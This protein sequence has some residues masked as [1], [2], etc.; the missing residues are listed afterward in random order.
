MTVNKRTFVLLALLVVPLFYAIGTGFDFLYTLLYAVLLL[1]AVGAGWAWVNLHGLD[2]R[3]SRTNDRGQVGGYLE[4]RVSVANRTVIPKSWLEVTE[5]VNGSPEPGGR[6]LSLDRRQSRA[7]RIRTFLA[8]RGLFEGGHV[9]VVSQDP[10]GLFRMSRD[11][12]DPHTY[13]VYPAV[14]PLPN[15]DARFAGLPSDS[16]ITRHFDQVTTDVAT[17]RDWRPGDAYRRI[18]WPYT[19]RMNSPMV[20]E[21]DVGLA[22]QFWLLL[23]LH[24]PSHHYGAPARPDV[25]PREERRGGTTRHWLDNTEE[26]AVTLTASMAQRL[27]ELSLPVGIAV[28]GDYGRMLRPDNGPDHLSRLMETLASAQ[29]TDAASM[30]Q[31]LHSMRPHLNHFHSV[32]VVT[33]NTDPS[34][35][36]ALLD[37]RRGNVTV[38][39]ALI[40]PASFGSDRQSEPVVQTAA[41]ELIPVYL[42]GREGTLDDA[43]SR[44]VNRDVVEGQD[45]VPA[46]DHGRAESGEPGEPARPANPANPAYQGDAAG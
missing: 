46:A 7:W 11:F 18:H 45:R 42:A 43:L 33:A 9:R 5:L 19:A 20:K 28:N 14:E 38:A 4:G 36:S 6:G 29:A 25:D 26:L 35:I 17:V 31:F 44:P 22:A 39:I 27:M 13:I 41:S 3:V 8:R 21:F 1:F 30:H 2:V 16:H 24:R 23:D 40:D 32:T 10:F 12:S 34:W 15:M 37:L